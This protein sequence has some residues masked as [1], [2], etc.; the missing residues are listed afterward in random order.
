LILPAREPDQIWMIIPYVAPRI[1]LIAVETVWLRWS[2]L[3]VAR[4]WILCKELC[5][6]QT[7]V[8]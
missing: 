6:S 1:A 8:T 3:L 5:S 2:D 7:H 4:M